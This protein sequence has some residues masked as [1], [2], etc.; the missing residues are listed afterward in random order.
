MRYYVLFGLGSMVLAAISGLCSMLNPLTFLVMNLAAPIVRL[1]QREPSYQGFSAMG[2][3]LEISLL[4]PLTLAPLH[5][6]NYRVLRGNGWGYA[7]MV[8]LASFLIAF[9]VLLR[10][11]NLLLQP[12]PSISN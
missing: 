6:L 11:S 10:H 4:W 9:I 2:T 7:G 12:A 5:Y 1:L 8:V 3:A